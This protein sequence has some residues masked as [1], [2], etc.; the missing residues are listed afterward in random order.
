VLGVIFYGI[1][2]PIGVV[3]RIAGRDAMC[4]KFDAAARSYWARR[5]P[6]GP[7]EGSFRNMF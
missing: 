3:M 7:A 5:D 2:T 6:P 1:F 4:R